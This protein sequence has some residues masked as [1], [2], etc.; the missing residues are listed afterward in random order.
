M[1]GIQHCFSVNYSRLKFYRSD[2]WTRYPTPRRNLIRW[3][4]KAP[5]SL[6]KSQLRLCRIPG[7]GVGNIGA[8]VIATK[9]NRTFL[10]K[11]GTL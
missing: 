1:A 3:F 9:T 11:K 4:F 8:G 2:I 7:K 5:S 6:A 10:V